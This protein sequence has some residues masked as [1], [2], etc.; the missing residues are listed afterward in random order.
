MLS[1]FDRLNL[2]PAERRLVVVILTVA[3]LVVN[4]WLVWPRFG[5][6]RTIAD[7]LASMERKREAYQRENERRPV[8]E[9]TLKKLRE[10]GSVLPAGEEKIQFRSDMERLAREVG[11]AVPRWGEVLPERN[12]GSTTNAFFEAIG[13]AMNQVT[14][15][16]AQFVD[17]LYR[18]GASN[19]TI[20]VKE[21]T[22]VPGNFDARAQGKTNLIGSIKLVASIQKPAPKPAATP[23][24]GAQAG[25]A[26]S[27]A[28]PGT[29]TRTNTGVVAPAAGVKP[30]T[31]AIPAPIRTAASVTN[32]PV[33][34][35]TPGSGGAVTNKA[36]STGGVKPAIPPATPKK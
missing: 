11:L 13:L 35:V 34:V 27:P 4:Y 6:F 7:D 26:T 1:L 36:A 33:N 3:F 9:A 29:G 31:N 5:D 20:R 23:A 24:A 19:S 10:A 12:S 17:F 28:A 15:T 18:V 14:G 25:T 16:E 22:L 32:R 21:L 2:T 30:R 8:Y